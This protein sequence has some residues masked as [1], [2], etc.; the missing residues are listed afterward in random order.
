[1]G[2][3]KMLRTLIF[4]YG[5]QAMAIYRFGVWVKTAPGLAGMFPLRQVLRLLHALAEWAIHKA[6]G[7]HLSIEA[8]IGP[9]FVIGHFGGVVVESGTIGRNCAIQQH[10]KIK[11]DQAKGKVPIIGDNVWIGAHSAIVGCTIG[12]R[13]TIAAGTCI[14]ADI[15]DRNL[16]AGNPGRVV[17]TNYDNRE[18]LG[19][20]V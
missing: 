11:K 4:A 1:M 15:G 13:A 19:I 17:L 5:L 3:T 14:D 2:F 8:E 16:V 18:I 6:Y 12:D 20:I 7:I 10:V 9:G